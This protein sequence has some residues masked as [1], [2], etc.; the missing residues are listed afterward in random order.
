MIIVGFSG[1]TGQGTGQLDYD[2][3]QP[4]MTLG[5]HIS[6]NVQWIPKFRIKLLHTRL[7]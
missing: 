1:G 6:D 3:G 5:N 2:T 7:M 4:G